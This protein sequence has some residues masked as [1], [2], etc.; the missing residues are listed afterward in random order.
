M[1]DETVWDQVVSQSQKGSKAAPIT[2]VWAQLNVSKTAKRRHLPELAREPGKIA[3]VLRETIRDASKG[4]VKWPLFV[5]S[6]P[7]LGK[8]CAALAVADHCPGSE[9]WVFDEYWR[10]V[11]DVNM[12]RYTTT[13]AGEPSGEGWSTLTR[14]VTWTVARWWAYIEKLPLVILDDVGLRNQAN[15]SQYEALKL[16]LD[17]RINRPTII[18]SN[19]APHEIGGVFDLRVMDRIDCGTVVLLEGKESLR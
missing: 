19:L 4:L 2:D 16:T 7:G 14:T 9:F 12:G 5:H 1:A 17:R 18:T 3:A 11:N 10:R 15:D 13:I 6:K 8:T